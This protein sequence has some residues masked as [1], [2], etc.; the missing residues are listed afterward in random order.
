M[1][2][3][4]QQGTTRRK[5]I[6][7]LAGTVGVA[8][9]GGVAYLTGLFGPSYPKTPYDDLLAK[10]P[11]RASAEVLGKALRA[12]TLGFDAKTVAASLR[13]RLAEKS[14]ADV[15]TADIESN[16]LTEVKGWVL[17][18]SLAQLSALTA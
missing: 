14:L 1:N 4:T 5:I 8:A 15:V 13:K 16:D 9:A 7:A 3:E 2:D 6:T 17:P 12:E 11:D 18:A 10:L